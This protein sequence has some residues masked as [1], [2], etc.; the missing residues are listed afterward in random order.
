MELVKLSAILSTTGKS[1]DK[2]ITDSYAQSEVFIGFQ[3]LEHSND[4]DNVDDLL[5]TAMM[6]TIV[7]AETPK[8]PFHAWMAMR[9]TNEQV[10]SK[11]FP[12]V[13]T[14]SKKAQGISLSR[15]CIRTDNARSLAVLSPSDG[16]D[17][18]AHT[19]LTLSSY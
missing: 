5:M 17:V 8:R 19:R 15:T 1:K 4:F 3:N 6:A 11:M 10:S 12:N 18:R 16:Q 13:D 9:A 14:V 7:D 2:I